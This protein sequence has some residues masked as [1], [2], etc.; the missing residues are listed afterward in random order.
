MKRPGVR[1]NVLIISFDDRPK[2]LW[3]LEDLIVGCQ[4][5]R[6]AGAWS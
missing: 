6:G 3:T 2:P 5:I 4:I 1:V